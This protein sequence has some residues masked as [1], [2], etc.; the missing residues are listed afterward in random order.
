MLR[1]RPCFDGEPSLET[2]LGFYRGYLIIPTVYNRQRDESMDKEA[3]FHQLRVGRKIN[4]Q[5]E[6][7][8]STISTKARG[9][10]PLD[11]EVRF[12]PSDESAVGYYPL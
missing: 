7:F 8:E 5:P 11:Q 9:V 6:I 12:V 2:F 1:A 4:L 3:I 10:L